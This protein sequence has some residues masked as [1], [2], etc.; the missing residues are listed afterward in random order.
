MYRSRTET[1][2]TTNGD[3]EKLYS[4]AFFPPTIAHEKFYAENMETLLLSDLY[5]PND[6][7]TELMV[8][9]P[10]KPYP[11]I[12]VPAWGYWW[13]YWAILS[14]QVF[15]NNVDQVEGQ[16]CVGDQVTYLSSP[17][18]PHYL[19]FCLG[20]PL[21]ITQWQAFHFYQ[22][23]GSLATGYC[24]FGFFD[25]EEKLAYKSYNLPLESWQPLIMDYSDLTGWNVDAGFNWASVSEIGFAASCTWTGNAMLIDSPRFY[26]A[27]VPVPHGRVDDAVVQTNALKLCAELWH[28]AETDTSEQWD[29]YLVY[30]TLE[31][32]GYKYS[33]ENPDP[34]KR[35]IHPLFARMEFQMPYWCEEFPSNHEPKMGS[36]GSSPVSIGFSAYGFGF[37]IT[38]SAY[39]I[40]WHQWQESGK[41]ISRWDMDSYWLF[42]T[43]QGFI[44]KD[45]VSFTLAFRVP[46]GRKPFVY[47]GAQIRWYQKTIGSLAPY[48][49]QQVY[50]ASVDPEGAG[51]FPPRDPQDIQVPAGE[52][53]QT[54]PPNPS[55]EER[56]NPLVGE[57]GGVYRCPPW[58]S[59]NGG[60]RNVRG[61]IDDD[62]DCDSLDLFKFR[63]AYVKEYNWKAD[64]DGDG[65]VDSYDLFIF[66]QSYILDIPCRVDG[67]YSWF[68]SGGGDYLMWQWLDFES[69]QAIGGMQ[70]TFSFWF[71]PTSV[72]PNGSQ[73]YARAEIFYVLYNGQENHVIGEEIHPDQ[74]TWFFASVT[75]DLPSSID[76]HYVEVIIHGPSNFKAWIDQASL[77]VKS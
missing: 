75:V 74:T 63:E 9:D 8:G 22:I 66:R 15:I 31:D 68:T 12:E 1:N 28:D 47:V 43:V 41:L 4:N 49:T 61:D 55:F 46:E 76:L 30:A 39:N 58:E 72:A 3:F 13:D 45:Y 32:I 57:Q 70:V 40:R 18:P 25:T 10:L 33:D 16:L 77:T 38:P 48:D 71:Y 42:G 2:E 29:Y 19:I 24:E 65:D 51:A 73:N 62:G 11:Y 35:F 52:L 6:E 27:G 64:F 7:L 34:S 44:F 20:S 59:N 14:N 5:P 21:D 36:Y 60:W 17:P 37:S 69:I 23:L 50:W 53:Q 56:A 54:L 26:R 67:I